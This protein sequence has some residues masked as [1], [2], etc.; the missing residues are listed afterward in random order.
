MD[1]KNK[2]LKLSDKNPFKI[3]LEM[4]KSIAKPTAP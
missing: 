4:L 1:V 2:P 3:T